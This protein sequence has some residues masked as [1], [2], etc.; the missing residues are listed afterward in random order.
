MPPFLVRGAG[1]PPSA[2]WPELR[3]ISTPSAI[4]I[5][6]RW[7]WAENC[8]GSAL[9]GEGQLGPHLTKCRLG[10]GLPSYQVA[11]WSIEPFGHNRYGP[12]IEVCAPLREGDLGPHLTE[13]GQGRGLPARQ[14][15]S[16]FVQSFGHNTPTLRF[17]CHPCVYPQIVKCWVSAGKK[18]LFLP[19]MKFKPREKQNTSMVVHSLPW[20]QDFLCILQDKHCNTAVHSQSHQLL[21]KICINANEKCIHEAKIRFQKLT[22]T[23][24]ICSLFTTQCMPMLTWMNTLDEYLT[25]S[26]PLESLQ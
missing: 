2:M 6:A 16:W 24:Q 22:V 12:K 18:N 10:Q 5:H 1:S 3:P 14:V 11:S 7:T 26:V 20:Q 9:F 4:L 15:S 19:D 17:I 25:N 21:C 13:C 8:R 23:T